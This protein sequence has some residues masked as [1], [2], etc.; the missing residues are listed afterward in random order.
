MSETL[1]GLLAGI[2]LVSTAGV[3]LLV[4]LTGIL[5]NVIKGIDI[6]SVMDTFDQIKADREK[7]VEEQAKR[8]SADGPTLYQQVQWSEIEIK[9]LNQERDELLARIASKNRRISQLEADLIDAKAA[10][11]NKPVSS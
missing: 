10:L 4:Y 1:Q 11:Q 7:A 9:R 8:Q 2:L 5:R 6:G 3:A